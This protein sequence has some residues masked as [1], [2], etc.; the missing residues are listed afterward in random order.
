MTYK[1][2]SFNILNKNKVPS[3]TITCESSSGFF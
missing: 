3:I 1:R 2:I